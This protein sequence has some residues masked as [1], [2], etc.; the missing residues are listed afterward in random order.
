MEPE[1]IIEALGL[2]PLE[3]EGGYYAETYRSAE[4]LGS[5]RALCTTIYYMLTPGSFSALHRIPSDE[6]YHFHLGDPVTML[7]LAPDGGSEVIALGSDPTRGLRPQVVVP[8]GWW[9]G[10]LLSE[11][12]LFAL[13]G[14][15]VAPGY[16]DGDLEIAA[17]EP[18]VTS[19]PDRWE[20][21]RRL[22]RV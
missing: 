4:R 5:G 21:I 9:Q 14:T 6:I 13:M 15:T 17:R 3:R 2:V 22:T 19:H 16:E 8:G 10:S 20:L 1:R 11:G 12:G 18:L 7:L